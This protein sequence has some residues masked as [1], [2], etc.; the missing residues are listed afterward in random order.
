M[1]G[2]AIR[3]ARGVNGAVGRRGG[4]F[5]ERYHAK[6]LGSP[7]QVRHALVYVLR[8]EAKHDV[9]RGGRVSSEL[10]PCSSASYFNGWR[11]RA[12]CPDDEQEPPVVPART[13]LLGPGWRI[14]G[15]IE[16]YEL[17]RLR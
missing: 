3:M 11:A 12:P 5:V 4:F 8:N 6:P 1:Q 7:R 2:L 17:P 15:L 9:Q 14:L 13:W 10:D 16:P